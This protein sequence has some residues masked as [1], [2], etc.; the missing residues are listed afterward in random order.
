VSAT[1]FFIQDPKCSRWKIQLADSM[2]T[3]TCAANQV[4]DVRNLE[5][6]DCM[7]SPH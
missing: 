5:Y 1:E 4:F 3:Q 2:E 7:V 6:R